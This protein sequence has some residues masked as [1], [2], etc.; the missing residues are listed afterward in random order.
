MI[1]HV[2]S[3]LSSAPVSPSPST[4]TP[5][6]PE[7][8]RRLAAALNRH[9]QLLAAAAEKGEGQDYGKKGCL[10]S[11]GPAVTFNL[12]SNSTHWPLRYWRTREQQCQILLWVHC[13][14]RWDLTLPPPLTRGRWF[15]TLASANSSI[16]PGSTSSIA[17]F[18]GP[19]WRHSAFCVFVGLTDVKFIT[20]WLRHQWS[21]SW[22]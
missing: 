12:P 19:Q 13:W 17:L 10:L 21:V 20:R 15:V 4:P 14:E 11:W 3:R 5:S 9:G 8:A 6:Q 16:W 7:R 2:R 1:P 18:F 22:T